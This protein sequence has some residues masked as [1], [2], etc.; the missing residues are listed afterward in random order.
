MNKLSCYFQSHQCFVYQYR[1]NVQIPGIAPNIQRHPQNSLNKEYFEFSNLL[2][3]WLLKNILIFT[4]W[5]CHAACG[6]LIPQPGIKAKPSTVE[7]WGSN[8]WT[9]REVPPPQNIL[10]FLLN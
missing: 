1:F 10:F 8:H 3:M 5:L 6:I 7:A 9:A 2:C 4:F